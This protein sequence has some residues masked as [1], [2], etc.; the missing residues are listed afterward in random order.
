MHSFKTILMAICTARLQMAQMWRSTIIENI[1]MQR[2][3]RSEVIQTTNLFEKLTM[4][5]TALLQSMFVF[6]DWPGWT[7]E[8]VV[9][10]HVRVAFVGAGSSIIESKFRGWGLLSP[11]LFLF[12][13]QLLASCSNPSSGQK[14]N[15]RWAR[16]T[17]Y[18]CTRRD[19]LTSYCRERTY[20]PPLPRRLSQR[21]S[22]KSLA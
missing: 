22:P 20:G 13:C 19:P 18:A 11:P 17:C 5:L 6:Q 21:W 2:L 3:S 16:S 10:E 4:L 14:A 1:S 8:C 7:G 9:V 15:F 12:G